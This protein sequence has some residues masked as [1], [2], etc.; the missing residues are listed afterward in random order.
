LRLWPATMRGRVDLVTAYRF[1]G[2]LFS[3]DADGLER[4]R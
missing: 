3:N 2:L 1:V 4:E